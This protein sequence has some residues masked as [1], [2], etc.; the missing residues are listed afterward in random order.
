MAGWGGRPCSKKDESFN[1]ALGKTSSLLILRQGQAGFE[2][3]EIHLPLSPKS[4][5]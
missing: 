2:L 4:W 3:L 5:D 1:I